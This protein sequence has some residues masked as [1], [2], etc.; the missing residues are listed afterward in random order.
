MA[1]RAASSSPTHLAPSRARVL[2]AAGLVALT[3]LATVLL[4]HGL[5][6]RHN[7]LLSHHFTNDTDRITTKIGWRMSAYTQ[8]LRGG[9]GLFAASGEVS[10]GQWKRYVEKLNLDQTYRGIQGVGFTRNIRPEELA[11]HEQAIRAQGYPAY[12]VNPPGEREIYTS[13]LYL[14]PFSGRNLRAFGF[15]MYSEAVRREA[16]ATARDTGSVVFT[17][18]VQLVQETD[19]DVQAG[20]LAYRST[21]TAACRRRWSCAERP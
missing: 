5:K 7:Q 20:I 1:S 18:K 3:L 17:G 4:M 10:R 12:K 11:Q 13:I 8:I 21:P 14:E 2:L 16:M 9:A 15:D 19:S 6:Q